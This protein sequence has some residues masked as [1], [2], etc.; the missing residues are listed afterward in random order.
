[1][2]SP[3]EDDR[4][5]RFRPYLQLLAR[6]WWDRR[7]DVKLDPSDVVQQTLLQA[8]QAVGQFRGKSDAELAAWLRKILAN[9]IAQSVRDLGRDKRDF[10]RERSLEEF[11]DKSSSRLEGWLED[12]EVSPSQKAQFKERALRVAEAI[13]SLP[14]AQREAIVLHYWQDRTANEIAIELGRTPAAVAGLLHRGLRKLE[15]ELADVQ[16]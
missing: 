12:A 14:E 2:E 4:L 15:S 10:R 5:A 1:M 9:A 8:H 13:E 3:A 11:L 7:L 6:I 16:D